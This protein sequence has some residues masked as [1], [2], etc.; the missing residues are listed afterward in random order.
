MKDFMNKPI[1]WGAYF[2][3]AGA[4]VLISGIITGVSMY[5]MYKD[6]GL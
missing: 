2:K 4:S 6:L 5:K 1:T 3:L